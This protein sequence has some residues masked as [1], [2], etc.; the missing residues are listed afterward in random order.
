MDKKELQDRLTK[1]IKLQ[2]SHRQDI[3]ELGYVISGL[4]KKIKSMGD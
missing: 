2:D 3:E 1:L 4:E